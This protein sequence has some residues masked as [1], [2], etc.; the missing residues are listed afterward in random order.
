MTA[1]YAAN[2][3]PNIAMSGHG[4]V[5][6]LTALLVSFIHLIDTCNHFRGLAL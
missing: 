3:L 2:L 1:L 5:V 6:S 4:T